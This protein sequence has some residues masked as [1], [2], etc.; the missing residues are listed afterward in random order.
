MKPAIDATE[1]LPERRPS[2][3]EPYASRHAAK[4]DGT[5]L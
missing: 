3:P 1:I 4:R 5:R 2:A